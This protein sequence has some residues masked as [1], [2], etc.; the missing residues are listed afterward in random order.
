LRLVV[1]AVDKIEVTDL[2][3]LSSAFE[4]VIGVSLG[5]RGRLVVPTRRSNASPNQSTWRHNGDP[6]P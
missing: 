5:T 3:T 2:K 4:A 6:W 1:G